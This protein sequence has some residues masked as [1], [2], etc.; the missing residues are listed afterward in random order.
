MA[1][2]SF[3]E[4]AALFD[5]TPVENMFITEY[6]LRAPGDFVK[7]YLYALML[8]YHN[9]ERMSLTSM[10]KDLDMT[11]EEVER[12]FR[13]WAR[14]GLCRQVGDQPVRYTL[15]NLKQITLTRAQTP[16]E[17]LYHRDFVEEIRRV[18][19]AQTVSSSD[20]QK[21]FD[22]VDV[23]EL[24][25][26][27]VLMLLQTERQNSRTGRVSIAIADKTAH[28]WAQGGVKTV[29]DVEK[30]VIIGREREN[31][32]R[33]LLARLGMR[34][35][36]SDDEKAMYTK[37][38]EEWGFTPDAV[39]EACRETTKGTPTM[40]YLDGILLRQHQLGRH[41]AA[42]MSSGMAKERTAR[43]FAR[44]V[45]AGLGRTGVT[46]SQDDLSVI[47]G[48][49]ERGFGDELI[50]MAVTAAHRRSGG[51]SMDDVDG[52][53]EK[54]QKQGLTT[55]EAV[56]AESARIR[57]LNAQLREIYEAAGLEKR[58]NAADRELLCRWAGE[59]GMSQELI[60]LAAQYARGGGSPMLF[61]GRI[62]SDWQRA[63]ISTLEAARAEH[64]SHVRNMPQGAYTKTPASAQDAML[65]Y[66]PEQ[67]R[68]TYSAA[69]LDFDE[70][71]S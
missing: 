16:S 39:Q 57:S 49:R 6:M 48:W 45:Y 2:C 70:E 42:A 10:A 37:W 9:A 52:Y 59:M 53:L 36:P 58:P 23:L 43:D 25:E 18:L 1:F 5:T 50:L 4:N 26:E 30:I 65:R 46:P 24:P 7:V 13:Y 67:R 44:D 60:V 51:G 62:L 17:Q 55:P 64:E 41:E 47:E 56:R 61:T 27:V 15:Y 66:T 63:G 34:R 38:I 29:E 54:W 31:H 71:D 3:D 32:L 11:E 14:E 40:A 69:V 35:T 28:E 12:A 22:W 19:D 33:K 21:I 68:K 20:L 8:C